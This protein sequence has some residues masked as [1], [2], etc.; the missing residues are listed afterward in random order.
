MGRAHDV[1]KDGLIAKDEFL[2]YVLGCEQS[3]FPPK[4]AP[5]KPRSTTTFRVGPIFWRFW[6]QNGRFWT[7]NG[8]EARPRKNRVFLGG[9]SRVLPRFFAHTLPFRHA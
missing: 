8:S 9:F 6:T 3:V 7:Q 2:A 5:W 4:N 1:D